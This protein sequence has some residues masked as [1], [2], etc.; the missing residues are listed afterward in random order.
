MSLLKCKFGKVRCS[1]NF[2][3]FQF[4]LPAAK[5]FS[6][7]IAQPPRWQSPYDESWVYRS[8]LPVTWPT[9]KFSAWLHCCGSVHP[10]TTSPNWTDYVVELLGCELLPLFKISDIDPSPCPYCCLSIINLPLA[11]VFIIPHHSPATIH[12][13]SSLL[14]NALPPLLTSMEPF[15]IL[16]QP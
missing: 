11:P 14:A 6:E 2:P 12:H 10:G 8:L 4:F 13:N 9:T 7:Q 15:F 1:N 3:I 5:C 16:I